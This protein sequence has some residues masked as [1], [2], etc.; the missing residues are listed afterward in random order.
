MTS[1]SGGRREADRDGILKERE[2]SIQRFSY[3]CSLLVELI[4]KFLQFQPIVQ[5]KF[6]QLPMFQLHCCICSVLQGLALRRQLKERLLNF[7]LE[8][9]KLRN[10]KRVIK[11][12]ATKSDWK[13]QQGSS[14]RPP[15][16]NSG[17]NT[18]DPLPL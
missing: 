3:T 14:Y 2:F 11:G 10:E 4:V 17:W 16:L 5:H 8:L 18:T 6:F 7:G 13:Y 9:K 15:N 12:G 1:D